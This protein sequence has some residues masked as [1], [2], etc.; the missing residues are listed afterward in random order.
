VCPQDDFSLN[1]VSVLNLNQNLHNY[2]EDI[3]HVAFAMANVV[4]EIGHSPYKMLQGR[5][6]FYPDAQRHRLGTNYEQISVNR[7]PVAT[8]NYQRNG[9][10]RMN[11]NGGSNPN[12]LPNS[13]DAIK[14]DQAYKEP[15]MEIFSDFAG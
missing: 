9:Q 4:D 1:N 14:I 7:C 5:L 2:F 11:G 10:M 6:L 12:C 3:G 15:L 13:F 8:H